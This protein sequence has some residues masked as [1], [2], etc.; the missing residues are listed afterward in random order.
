MR[1]EYTIAARMSERKQRPDST[2]ADA[3][4]RRLLIVSIAFASIVVFGTLGLYGLGRAHDKPWTMGDCAYMTITTVVTVGYGEIIP[5]GEVPGGRLLVATLAVFGLGSALLFTSLFTGFLIEGDFLQLRLRRKM[6][7]ALREVKDHVIVCGIGTTGVHVVEELLWTKRPLVAIDH[8]E[9]KL[10]KLQDL[11]PDVVP[12]VA[13]NAHDDEVLRAAGIDRAIGLVSALTDDADNLYVVLTARTLNPKL[14]IVS[15]GVEVGATDKL[16]RAGADAVVTP[17]YIGGVR[18]VSE[19]VRPQVVEFLDLML[20][21]KDKNLR[22]EEV[23]L[24]AESSLVGKQLSDSRIRSATN[25][26]IVAL[27]AHDGRFIYNP[28]PTETLEAGMALIV[29]GET[30]QVLKLRAAVAQGFG[31]TGKFPAIRQS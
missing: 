5:V 15:K 21:D 17:S 27:R 13:G 9:D 16:R 25:L 10:N 20:R 28:G 1:R 18:M 19:M 14:R 3:S 7:K 24:P 2:A 8:D 6:Q 11:S 23:T 30:D 29:L 31:G 22:I 4:R 12:I 26:L